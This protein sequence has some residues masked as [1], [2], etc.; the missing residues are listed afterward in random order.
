MKLTGGRSEVILHSQKNSSLD[1]GMD[2][3]SVLES[4]SPY[5]P[6]SSMPDK[7]VWSLMSIRQNHGDAPCLDLNNTSNIAN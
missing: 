3:S 1:L 2:L 6:Y 5:Q 7:N 4:S